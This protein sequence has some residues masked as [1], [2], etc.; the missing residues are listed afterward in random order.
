MSYSLVAAFAW[1]ILANV[2]AMIPSNDHHW[3]RAFFLIAIGVPLLG[4]VTY[5]TGPWMG[6]LCLAAGASVLR[7]PLYFLGR[8]LK[9]RLGFG[10][11]G[12]RS[13]IQAEPAD[14]AGVFGPCLSSSSSSAASSGSRRGSTSDATATGRSSRSWR[15]SCWGRSC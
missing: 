13:V 7:W 8:W 5:E 12:A 3:R 6:L 15:C 1:M 11:D 14:R 4:W 10:P 2:L 9:R